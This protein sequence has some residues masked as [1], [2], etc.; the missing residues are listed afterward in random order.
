MIHIK[1]NPKYS[2]L[3]P[4]LRQLTLEGA[5]NE[6]GEIRCSTKCLLTIIGKCLLYPG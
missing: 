4:Y 5:F 6:G 2:H 1:I 3:E